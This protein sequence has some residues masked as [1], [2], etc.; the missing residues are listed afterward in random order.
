MPSSRAI[1]AI[2]RPVVRTSSTASRLNSGVN[3][4]LV[5]F[6][7]SVI[8]TPSSH[9]RCPANRGKS[10]PAEDGGAGLGA[11]AVVVAVD[12]LDFQRG[13]PALGDGVVQ[14]R[15]GA[16]HRA[17]KPQPLAGLDAGA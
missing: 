10:N 17:A 11:G 16:A 9:R 7:F 6:C 5:L 2:G 15:S 8:W 4:R 14:A 12:Q 3:C 13:E 1:S